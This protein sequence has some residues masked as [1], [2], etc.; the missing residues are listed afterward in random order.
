[1]LFRH[2]HSQPSEA[3]SLAVRR[4]VEKVRQQIGTRGIR[5]VDL[6]AEIGEDEW[7]LS[8]TQ[9]GRSAPSTTGEVPPPQR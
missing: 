1:M 4:R 5:V 6:F 3:D 2:H 9:A 7:V 8:G